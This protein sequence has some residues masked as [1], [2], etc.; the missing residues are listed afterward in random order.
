ME[1]LGVMAGN[2]SL[3]SVVIP[4]FNEEDCIEALGR[5]LQ[6]VFLVE[7]QYQFEVIVVD[8]GSIDNTLNLLTSLQNQ[9]ARFKVLELSRNFGADGGITAG[10]SFAKGDAAVIMMADLQE[11]P[12]LI[13]AMLRKWEAGYENIYGLVEKRKGVGWLRRW[14]SKVFYAI[15]SRLSGGTI[16]QN[17]SD[18]RLIDKKV[19]QEVLRLRE[20]SR[21]LRGLFS[22]VGFRSVGIP[23]ERDAR[24][25]GESKAKT[26]TVVALALRG[27][28]SNSVFPLRA[29]SFVGV[30]AAMSAI[31]V[32][33]YFTFRFLT[34]GV[35]FDG[36]GTLV[37][38][39]LLGFS[40]VTLFLGVIGEYLGLTY[41][42]TRARPN[43]IV[44]NAWGF[45]LED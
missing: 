44:R 22:W 17:A 20:T 45:G 6:E 7:S 25:G 28:L 9:D 37:G 3:V 32:F 15:A 41:E 30:L 16:V 19:Y 8:N 33:G 10:L 31:A 4:A 42:E 11:P 23:F 40:F 1:N 34:V 29:I 26:R 2:G 35:P 24:H 36:F 12:S 21:F 39:N 13:S 14:N 38:L 5:G 27:I 18:F 43:F